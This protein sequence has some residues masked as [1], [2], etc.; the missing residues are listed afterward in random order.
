M[1]DEPIQEWNQ[2]NQ[3][4]EN[5]IELIPVDKE[6]RDGEDNLL[7]QEMPLDKVAVDAY[8][9]DIPDQQLIIS[10]MDAVKNQFQERQN[11]SRGGREH[12][13]EDL[14]Q[15]HFTSPDVTGGDIDANWERA[16]TGSG[17]ESVGGTEPTPDQDVIDELGQAVGITYEDDEPLNIEK[18]LKERRKNRL[19]PREGQEMASKF[20]DQHQSGQDQEQKDD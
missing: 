19:E 4:Q 8:S 12:L 10:E 9:E 5:D 11:L 17:A 7:D 2:N 14:E 13:E 18:K 16:H 15:H 20:E 6:N 3:S 1:S